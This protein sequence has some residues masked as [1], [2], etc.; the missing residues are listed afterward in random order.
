MAGLVDALKGRPGAQYGMDTSGR[1]GHV[2]DPEM[3]KLLASPTPLSNLIPPEPTVVPAAPKVEASQTPVVPPSVPI[4][5]TSQSFD[6]ESQPIDIV[7]SV[8]GQA[9]TSMTSSILSPPATPATP[10]AP[11]GVEEIIERTPAGENTDWLSEAAVGLVPSLIGAL[12]GTSAGFKLGGQGM[13]DRQKSLEDFNRKISLRKAQSAT[14]A[15][16]FQ[17]TV[18]VDDN[19]RSRIGRFNPQTGQIERSDQD[20]FAGGRSMTP[21]QVQATS[22]ARNQE[23]EISYRN[24]GRDQ[25]FIEREDGTKAILTK[26]R[27]PRIDPLPTNSQYTPNQKKFIETQRKVIEDLSK[28]DDSSSLIAKTLGDLSRGGAFAEKQ[29]V[30]ALVKE[31]EGRMSDQDRAFYTQSLGFL[32]RLEEMKEMQGT[33]RLPKNLVDEIR[34]SLQIAYD[35]DLSRLKQR[36]DRVYNSGRIHNIPFEEM[37]SILGGPILTNPLVRDPKSGSIMRVPRERL[38]EALQDGGI[39]VNWE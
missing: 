36:Y 4:S 20:P 33:G 13:V 18:Y 38:N 37:R 39:I 17:Q 22:R 24:L 19:N 14:R 7:G 10:A 8:P 26:G 25:Q 23:N 6:F 30:M 9:D 16:N 35:A 28:Y 15:P 3:E 5:P 34:N 11:V 32:K 12:T 21:E 29:A 27:N 2:V 1:P 31:L